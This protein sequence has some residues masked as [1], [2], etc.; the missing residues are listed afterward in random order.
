MKTDCPDVHD[1][2]DE[3]DDITII[4]P[5]DAIC[6][7]CE[8]YSVVGEA[9]GLLTGRCRKRPSDPLLDCKS[10]ICESYKLRGT[11]S[12]ENQN[13]EV[14]DMD[15]SE[16]KEL[17]KEVLDETMGISELKM[18]GKWE[19]GDIVIRPGN[20]ELQEK[21]IPIEAFFHKIVMVRDRLRVLEQRINSHK[22]LSD[23]DKVELQQYV[24]RV[25]GSL[26]TF[27]VLFADKK[28]HF[29]GEKSK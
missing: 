13:L 3:P 8:Y 20:R 11:V 29:V 7:K 4:C 17:L 21:V 25:Y 27:N 2:K 6:G 9:K 5:Y 15:R 12:E 10:D 18:G 28:D 16:L 26:T 22:D 1:C 19:G 24:T 14:L 23:E